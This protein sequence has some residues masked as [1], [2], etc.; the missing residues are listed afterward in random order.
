MERMMKQNVCLLFLLFCPFL[1]WASLPAAEVNAANR[2]FKQGKFDGAV[3]KYQAALEKEAASPLI[4]YNLGTAL[5]KKGDYA[6]AVEH[7][8]KA[9]GSKVK[10]LDPLAQYNLGDALYKRGLGQ[11]DKDID[12]AIAD[13]QQDIA[14]FDQVLKMN[15]KDADAQYNKKIAQQE[16]QRLQQLKEKRQQQDQQQQEKQQQGQQDQKP[17]QQQDKGKESPQ[18]GSEN[19][20]KSKPQENQ[21]GSQQP[22]K[23]GDGKQQKQGQGEQAQG[24]DGMSIKEA[25]DSLEDYERNEGPKGLLNFVPKE[26]SEKPVLKDW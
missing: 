22:A 8:D 20:P 4:E 23:S 24:P 14:N 17:N 12:A 7:L 15:A 16:L 19:Q 9:V 6:S 26:K 25:K 11:E 5:Y 10:G 13:V 1:A 21:E 2:L 18:G 3:E